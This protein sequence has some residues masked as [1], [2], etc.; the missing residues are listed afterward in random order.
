MFVAERVIVSKKDRNNFTT[1][2]NG[3]LHNQNSNRDGV[4]NPVVIFDV[5]VIRLE[6][7]GI[8]NRYLS[9]LTK[10]FLTQM[11]TDLPHRHTEFNSLISNGLNIDPISNVNEDQ[12]ILEGRVMLN[13]LLSKL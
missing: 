9:M 6:Q 11:I 8:A 1:N 12:L 7:L 2:A 3:S 10:D 5:C 4:N 13:K